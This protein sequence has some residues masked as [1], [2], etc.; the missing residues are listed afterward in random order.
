MIN[1]QK[2]ERIALDLMKAKALQSKNSLANRELMTIRI[3]FENAEQL[4]YH[5]KYLFDYNGSK[6][7]FS[8]ELVSGWSEKWLAVFNE[9]SKENLFETL[10]EVHCP[11]Y[12][13]AGRNDYQTNSMLVEQYFKTVKA[14]SKDFYWFEKAGHS[15]PSTFGNRMQEIIIDKILKVPAGL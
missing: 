5:R 13:F 11:I 15:I 8:K 3:P 7:P 12:F 2:S 4:Y 10:P 9:A 14:P 1:Q 6:V